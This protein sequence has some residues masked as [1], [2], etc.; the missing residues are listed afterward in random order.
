MVELMTY[1]RN[2]ST[3]ILIGQGNRQDMPQRLHY[4]TLWVQG[5]RPTFL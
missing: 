2:T 1:E 4:T 5:R 3:L